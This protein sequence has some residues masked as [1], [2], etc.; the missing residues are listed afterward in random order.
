[1]AKGGKKGGPELDEEQ[2]DKAITALLKWLGKRKV[3][4]REVARPTLAPARTRPLRERRRRGT[5]RQET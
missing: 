1:M 2:L 4:I 5:P 3:R